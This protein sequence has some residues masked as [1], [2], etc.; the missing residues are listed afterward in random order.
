MVKDALREGGWRVEAVKKRGVKV[1]PT[2]VLRQVEVESG[3]PVQLVMYAIG[4]KVA[5]ALVRVL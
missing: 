5:V 4:E 1:E 2:S 3:D